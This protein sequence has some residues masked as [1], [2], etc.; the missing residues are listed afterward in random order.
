MVLSKQA[1]NSKKKIK[2]L[3][4]YLSLITFYFFFNT[5]PSFSQTTTTSLEEVL[6]AEYIAKYKQGLETENNPDS[7]YLYLNKAQQLAKEIAADSLLAEIRNSYAFFIYGRGKA[8]EAWFIFH[9]NV[10]YALSVK[11]SFLLM[12]TYLSM[13]DTYKSSEPNYAPLDS[14]IY[15]TEKGLLLAE[16][17][18]DILHTLLAKLN[19]AW[20]Y[21]KI[22]QLRK[23]AQA[24]LLEAIP[25]TDQHPDGKHFKATAY[26]D[27]ADYY[28]M[29]KEWRKAIEILK[30]SIDYGQQ[31][32]SYGSLLIAYQDLQKVYES[33]GEYQQSLAAYKE[34][35]FYSEKLKGQEMEE[36]IAELE[37][38]FEAERKE[39]QI[40]QLQLSNLQQKEQNQ[41]Q[42]TLLLLALL[43]G[44]LISL[45]AYVAWRNNKKSAQVLLQLSNSQREMATF[46]T[47]FYTNLTH[48]FR[49]PLTVIQGM[50]SRLLGNSEAKAMIFRNSQHLLELVNQMLDLQKLDANALELKYIQG[51]VI[52][53]LRYLLE[54]HAVLAQYKSIHLTIYDENKSLLMDYDAN[55]L[56]QI[57]D[58]LV[59]NAIKFTKDGGEIVV[60]LKKVANHLQIVV[61]DTGIGIASKDIAAI[62]DRFYQI[63]VA[64]KLQSSGTGIGLALTKELVSLMK[65]DIQVESE[66]QVGTTFTVTLPIHHTASI[67]TALPLILSN[68]EVSTPINNTETL[69]S[70]WSMKEDKPTILLVEDNKDV[71]RFLQLTL[72]EDYHFLNATNGKAGLSLAFEKIPDLIISDIMMPE[73]DGLALCHTL[74]ND[75]RSSHIPIILLTAKATKASQLEGLA[76]G[77]DAYI[78]KPF[79]PQELLI[80]VEQLLENRRKLQAYYLQ[81]NPYGK[82]T[83][84]PTKESPF[85]LK[86]KNII[87]KNLS[88]EHFGA[89]QLSHALHLSRMQVHRKLK[90]VCDKSTAQFIREIRLQKAHHL[91]KTTDQTIGEIAYAVGFSDPAYFSKVFKVFFGDLPSVT[92]K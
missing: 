23:K 55:H 38:T 18:K 12:R 27:L 46:K 16:Q 34:A 50:T 79:D 24:I 58:N 14:L 68:K 78:F 74:K 11:D 37:A 15:Y 60:H 91:L 92:R 5:A 6:L 17:R 1:S 73:M 90:A 76:G 30:V 87:E 77:A 45:L 29:D 39:D 61:K 9:K 64:N 52:A 62:F 10:Q 67:T 4:F 8:K 21:S 59:S 26:R 3:P 69:S 72:Q 54:P 35:T 80:R 28:L 33:I 47:R 49:T 82:H 85:L 51:D 65:G 25:L 43:G 40:T 32:E 70:T 81:W 44:V 86:A 89:V 13:G 75:E 84:T 2:Q 63:E 7:T 22:P 31:Y 19:L 83:T 56:K 20:H 71:L 53:Y 48:E 36:K 66:P 42:R 41:R 57:L 88:D